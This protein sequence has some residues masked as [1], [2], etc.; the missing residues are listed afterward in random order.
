MKENAIEVMNWLKCE[1]P[2][3][4][5]AIEALLG[6]AWLKPRKDRPQWLVNEISSQCKEL[7]RN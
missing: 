2:R 5:Q 7:T 3:K 4:P 1:I 6:L